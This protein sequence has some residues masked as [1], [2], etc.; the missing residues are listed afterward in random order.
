M[1]GKNSVLQLKILVI[2]VERDLPPVESAIEWEASIRNE[3]VAAQ[4][5]QEKK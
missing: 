2:L 1:T 4:A 3:V 5:S